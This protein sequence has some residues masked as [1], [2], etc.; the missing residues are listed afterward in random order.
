M[1]WTEALDIVIARTKHEPYRTLCAE[2]HPHAETWRER[3]VAMATGQPLPR[4]V[5][6][7]LAEA[8]AE[9]GDAPIRT[10]PREGCCG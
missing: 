9:M 7:V 3:M 6:A 1:D 5:D 10:E 4:A 8:K 2:G